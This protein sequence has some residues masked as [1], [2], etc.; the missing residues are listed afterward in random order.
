MGNGS[1]H[2]DISEPIGVIKPLHGVNNGPLGY[3]S[4]VDVSHHYRDLAIP[5]VRL[6]DPNWP[7]PREV[8][9]PQVFRN[10]AAHP[11][12]PQAFDF[13]STDAYLEKIVDTGAQII[14][15]LGVS[16]E[17]TERKVYTDPP[18]DF[19]KWARICLGIV[20]HYNEGWA[21]GYHNRVAYWEVWNEADI[22][23]HMWSG[24]AEQYFALYEATAKL[25]KSHDPSIKIGGPATARYEPPHPQASF[26]ARFLE[27]CRSHNCP[28]DF[29]SWHKY[30]TDPGVMVDHARQV[31]DLLVHYGYGAVESHLNEWN[32]GPADWDIWGPG[33]EHAR[34][35][36]FE[37]QKNE[38]GASFVATILTRLQDAPVDV[39]TYYDGQPSALFCGLFDYYGVAQ[40]TFYA[41]KAFSALLGHPTR[42]S[43]AGAHDDHDL[44]SLA[45]ADPATGAAAILLSRFSGAPGPVEV[46]LT[47]LPEARLSYKVTAIDAD[48]EF[49]AVERGL[50][51]GPS[52]A[53][54]T[55]LGTYAVALVTLAPASPR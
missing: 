1:V 33:K 12:D 7:H 38:V 46:Q 35:Q 37:A 43:A 41:M 36:S 54:T 2:V 11:D 45:A 13:A 4:L 29:V 42:V 49:E 22:G 6:H 44:H 27:Y 10:F 26:L 55:R 21:R 16:I 40:R 50:L 31:R 39:A 9:V 20:R 15:R 3:G 51:H 47:G 19:D 18:T 28:L 8:D 17:H 14:Y 30:T 23:D 52:A 5:Y 53:L 48:S 34:R 24:T 25:L 32:Y